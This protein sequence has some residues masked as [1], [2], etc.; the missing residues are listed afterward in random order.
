MSEDTFGW[1]VEYEDSLREQGLSE[2]EISKAV[3]KAVE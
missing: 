1:L 2:D 3:L